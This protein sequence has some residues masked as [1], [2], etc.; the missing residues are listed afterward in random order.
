MLGHHIGAKNNEP[1][2]MMNFLF[3]YLF[4]R[5]FGRFI[6]FSSPNTTFLC[7]LG[8]QSTKHLNLRIL[9]SAFAKWKLTKEV[10]C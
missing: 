3:C 4:I 2:L 5:Y 1:N 9:M 7:L 8:E 10:S 6:H